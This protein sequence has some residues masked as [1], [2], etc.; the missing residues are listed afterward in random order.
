M[1]RKDREMPRDFGLAIIDKAS[2]GVLSLADPSG[3]AYG[4]P[5]SFARENNTLYFHA[6]QSGRKKQ[7]LHDGAKVHVVFVGEVQ[8]PTTTTEEQAQKAAQSPHTFGLLTSKLFTTEFESAMVEGII[9][10]VSDPAGKTRGLQLIC[11][12]YA[13]EWMQYFAQAAADGMQKTDV[14][15]IEMVTLTAKRKKFDAQGEEMKW[16]RT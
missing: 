11:Q 7:M 5:L 10:K 4:V 15:A 9:R 12:K 6:A 1:R 13:P 2:Y 16:Q 14:Y 8:A 3:S